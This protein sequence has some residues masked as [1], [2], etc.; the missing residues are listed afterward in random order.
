MKRALVLIFC[1]LI[2]SETAFAFTPVTVPTAE[3]L[4]GGRPLQ[5]SAWLTK[6]ESAGLFPAVVMLH[7]CGG[8]S[9]SYRQ[10]IDRLTKWGYVVLAVDSFTARGTKRICDS[11]SQLSSYAT[12]RVQDAY[13]GKKFLANLPH[14]DAKRI[15]LMGW[16]HGGGVL[17]NALVR[18]NDDAFQ[19]AIAFYP[20]CSFVL[21]GLNAPLLIL[22]GEKDDWTPAARC[23]QSMVTSTKPEVLLHVYPGAF[24]AFDLEGVDRSTRGSTGLHRV[25]HNP[26]AA[27]DAIDRVREFLRTQLR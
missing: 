13:D 23:R 9:Q 20:W 15:A 7:G 2:L 8:L 5:L 19:A 12:L 17:L 10:W 11:S 21:D 25:L 27:S 24:H 1:L 4:A 18:K 16:S 22:V 26:A 14:V 3:K 6:P